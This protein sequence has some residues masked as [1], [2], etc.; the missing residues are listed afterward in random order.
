MYKDTKDE[1]LTKDDK[2]EEAP[3]DYQLTRALDLI[4]GVSLF[5]ANA[6]TKSN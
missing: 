2:A 3:V 5:I 1:K 4:S 6:E